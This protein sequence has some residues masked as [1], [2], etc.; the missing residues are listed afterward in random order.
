MHIQIHDSIFL[1]FGK[2]ILVLIMLAASLV[3]LIIFRNS[4]D[5]CKQLN[6]LE[7]ECDDARD[8]VMLQATVARSQLAEVYERLTT[9]QEKPE[10]E[11]ISNLIKQ[12]MPLVGLFMSKETS[13][14]KWGMAGANLARSAFD[15]FKRSEKD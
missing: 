15:Y 11:V 14:I 7:L 5:W 6:L 2:V 13:L 1:G 4:S 9:Q 8:A 3:C 12:A 10:F